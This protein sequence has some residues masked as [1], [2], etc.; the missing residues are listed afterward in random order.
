[1]VALKCGLFGVTDGLLFAAM[2]TG[3]FMLVWLCFG[4]LVFVEFWF[5]VVGCF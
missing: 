4:W 2:L 3:G 1:M 5:V